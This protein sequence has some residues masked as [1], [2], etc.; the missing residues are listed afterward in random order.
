VDS[1]EAAPVEVM[2]TLHTPKFAT[3]PL[4]GVT[5]TVTVGAGSVQELEFSLHTPFEHEKLQDPLVPPEQLPEDPPCAVAESAQLLMV[6]A[7]Q[8]AEG[9]EQELEFRLHVPLLQE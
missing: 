1:Q 5:E 7:E 2:F 4:A 3:D 6:A 9:S 8:G